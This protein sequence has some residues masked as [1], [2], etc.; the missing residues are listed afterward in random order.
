M[1]FGRKTDAGKGVEVI[2]GVSVG[3]GGVDVASCGVGVKMA[4]RVSA[5]TVSICEFGLGRKTVSSG[6]LMLNLIRVTRSSN[7][8]ARRE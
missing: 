8:Q 5:T 7:L 1:T 2:V 3:P 4:V 6:G